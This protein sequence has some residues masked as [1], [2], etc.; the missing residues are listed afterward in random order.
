MS[1]VGPRPEVAEYVALWSEDDRKVI[2]SV[3]PGITDP[4]TLELRR[5][6]E[7]LA[8]QADPEAFYRRVL[9]PKKTR[10]YREYVESRTFTGDL[11]VILRT[12]ASVVRR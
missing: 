4:A 6:E 5:E 1:I 9:L 7:L 11:V 12:L 10:L 3:R 2:L 8:D